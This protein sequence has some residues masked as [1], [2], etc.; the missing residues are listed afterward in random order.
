MFI[1]KPGDVQLAVSETTVC[2]GTV[3]SLT[4]S[5]DSNPAV[6]SYQ[7]YEN[8]V[9]VSGGSSSAWNRSMSTGGG[10]NYTCMVNNTI[11]IAT[12][13]SVSLTVNG[14]KEINEK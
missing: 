7:L 1:D 4:C 2:S 14:K 3:I 5:A 10:F 11:G 13:T 9:L 6:D 12:S 8:N